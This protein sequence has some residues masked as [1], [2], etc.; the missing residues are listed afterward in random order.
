MFTVSDTSGWISKA[1]GKL[2]LPIIILMVLDGTG[3]LKWIWKQIK[4]FM[5]SMDNH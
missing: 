1:I 5:S 2:I 4:P 3:A